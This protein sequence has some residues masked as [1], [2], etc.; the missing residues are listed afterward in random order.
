MLRGILSDGLIL[1]GATETISRRHSYSDVKTDIPPSL[2]LAQ[3]SNKSGISPPPDAIIFTS[4]TSANLTPT[5]CPIERSIPRQPTRRRRRRRRGRA[6]YHHTNQTSI[7]FGLC[8][9]PN[10]DSSPASVCEITTTRSTPLPT[11]SICRGCIWKKPRTHRRWRPHGTCSLFCGRDT[12]N[13]LK[14]IDLL[15]HSY[16]SEA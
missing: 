12:E 9:R 3:L 6:E 4:I 7:P 15:A 5:K 11:V 1:L 8:S 13:E 14:E 2:S 16:R 10:S